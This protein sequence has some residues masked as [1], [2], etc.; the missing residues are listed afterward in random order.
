MSSTFSPADGRPTRKDVAKLAKVSGTTVSRVLGGRPDE[1]VS[2]KARQRVLDAARQLGYTP[3]PAAK[4]LRSGRTGLVGLWMCLEYSNYRSQVMAQMREILAETDFALSVIDVDEDYAGR[5]TLDRA[6]RVPVEGIIAFEPSRVGNAL[7]ELDLNIPFV[8]MGAFC[9]E[10]RSY[11]AVDLEAGAEDAMD[12]LISTGRQSIAYVAPE[13]TEF[14][15]GGQRYDGYMRK[16]REAGLEPRTLE[17]CDV[18]SR[19]LAALQAVLAGCV[20]AG[21]LPDALLCFYDDIAVDTVEALQ[22]L[23]LIPGKDV[24]VVGFNGQIGLSRRPYPISTVEQPIREMCLLAFRYLLHQLD[25][26]SSPPEQTTLKPCLVI[27]ESSA[28]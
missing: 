22:N 3:N 20:A 11:V 13:N 2:D 18:P 16:M 5:H 1:S 9:I 17:V 25:D 10:S 27:R 8:S 4:A 7:V 23:G 26:P 24:A 14:V 21:T 15:A 19:R 12:H 6:L 28:G